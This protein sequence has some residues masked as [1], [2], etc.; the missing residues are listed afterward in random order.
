VHRPGPTVLR[1]LLLA[2]ARPLLRR[3]FHLSVILCV[4]VSHGDRHLGRK[5]AGYP[6][7]LVSFLLSEA[8]QGGLTLF[9]SELLRSLF[10]LVGMD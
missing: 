10:L 6:L 9:S 8:A 3:S 7:D 2:L 4:R 5:L 1:L